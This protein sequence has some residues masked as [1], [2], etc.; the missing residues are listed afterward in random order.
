MGLNTTLLG[1][2]GFGFVCIFLY[3]VHENSLQQ[4]SFTP[5]LLISLVKNS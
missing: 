3:V 2:S 5:T 1:T 4:S